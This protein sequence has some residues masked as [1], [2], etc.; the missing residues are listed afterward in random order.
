MIPAYCKIEQV[1]RSTQIFN[2]PV[3]V[4][5]KI[6]GSQF[7]WMKRDGVMHFRSKNQAIDPANAG[8]FQLGVNALLEI[9]EQFPD[10][11]LYRGEYLSKPKHNVLRYEVLPHRHVVL[12]DVQISAS[13]E[14]YLDPTA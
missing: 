11:W 7:S 10:Y 13:E 14:G 3:V 4:E 8:M 9:A 1:A 2:G 12:Y 5:E 6:D